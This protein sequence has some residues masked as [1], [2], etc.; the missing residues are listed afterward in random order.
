MSWSVDAR[1]PLA[2]LET[3]VALTAALAVAP[4]AVALRDFDAASAH[5]PACTCCVGRT[6]V[7]VALDE[8]FQARVRGTLPW[9]K[10]VV[11]L[12]QTEEARAALITALREDAL[13]AARFRAA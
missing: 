11:A 9:F 4:G 7:A 2:I 6:P 1:I 13:T 8:L 10:R 12:A 5:A 3:E